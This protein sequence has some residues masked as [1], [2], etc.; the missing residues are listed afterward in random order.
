MA[1]RRRG[2]EIASQMTDKELFTSSAFEKYITK[3]LDF[4]LRKHKLYDLTIQYDDGPNGTTAFTDGKN[5]TI[6]AGN[7][8][9]R[10]PRILERRFK[11][12]MGLGFH[13]A[14]HRLFMDFATHKK[15]MKSIAEGKLYGKFDTSSDP[16]L[17][18]SLDE[19]E[20]VT[21]SPYAN[22]I[23]TL[24]HELSNIIGDGHDERA[25]MECFPGFITDCI[26]T[27]DDVQFEMTP[28][29]SEFIA[30]R[31]MD[32]S[33]LMLLFL[34]YS[35]F[36]YYK[37]G[38]TT[39]E[40]EKYMD[41]M[42]SLEPTLDAALSTDSL[43]ERWNYFNLLVLQIWPYIRDM[44][45]KKQNQQQN[46]GQP[47]SSS[48]GGPGG[49]GGGSQQ[50]GNQSQ[51]NGNGGSQPAPAPQA[52][53]PE[54]S[55]TPSP[56]AVSQQLQQL[57]QAIREATGSSPVP[58]NG[59]GKG[60][61]REEAKNAVSMPSSSSDIS[62]IA[63]S[64]AQEQAALQIQ[65]ELNQEQ[66]NAI[67]SLNFPLVHQATPLEI[68]QSLRG[69]K[70]AYDRILERVSKTTKTLIQD[71]LELF[72]ECNDDG[73]EQHGYWGETFDASQAFAWDRKCFTSPKLP[74][75]LPNM[76][77]CLLIDQSGSMSGKKLNLAMDT[78]ILLEHFASKL[79]IPIMIAGHN[80]SGT[81]HLMVYKDFI[82]AMTQE[83]RHSLACMR[84]DRGNRDGF[85][86]RICAEELAKR[87]EDIRLLITIS[88]GAPADW[89]YYGEEAMEDISKT[90]KE[91]RNKGLLIYGAAI[92]DDKDVIEKIYGTGF[93]SISKLEKLP[94]TMV[95]LIRQHLIY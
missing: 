4:I 31:P 29:L 35:V 44:F 77:I 37:V 41:I 90:V 88:D 49:A 52:G 72:R 7:E 28:S 81:T 11:V 51:S 8:M 15:A 75:D 85:A 19:L 38:D 91:F 40:T 73:D 54:D 10:T 32:Y 34:E 79:G 69:N 46:Q 22:A 63:Q 1:I 18:A 87:S 57:A 66:M 42:A 84:S 86:L 92:D 62:S 12:L 30:D 6:N 61:S 58:V 83:A 53:D 36:G 43:K 76:S 5:I 2:N 56:N 14:S 33:I 13:E 93:I 39:P 48:P 89:G 95:N 59:S 9:V 71:M 26:Q 80:A 25:M 23:A 3:L 50:Q 74:D 45:P 82:S 68:H 27:M 24:Y 78:A 94:R 47:Q 60:V 17:V 21:A 55:S 70:N 64:M 20:E 67:R 16:A 65:Q